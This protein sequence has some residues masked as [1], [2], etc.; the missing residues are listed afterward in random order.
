[1]TSTSSMAEPEQAQDNLKR[2]TRLFAAASSMGRHLPE[3]A[4]AADALVGAEAI[5]DEEHHDAAMKIAALA[6]RLLTLR[7]MV[8]MQWPWGGPRADRSCTPS[9]GSTGGARLA[10]VPLLHQALGR[11]IGLVPSIGAIL[12]ALVAAFASAFAF[13]AG[14]I[15]PST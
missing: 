3:Q 9:S 11:S 14:I 4:P 10:Q 8:P 15:S 2:W 13:S 7:R 5:A 6:M 12:A 1:M